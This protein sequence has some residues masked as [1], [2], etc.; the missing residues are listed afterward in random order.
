[1]E[2]ETQ[3][4]TFVVR[5]RAAFVRVALYIRHHSLF[6]SPQLPV[7]VSAYQLLQFLSLLL[8][9]AYP[10]GQGLASALSLVLHT[11][12]QP[13]VSAVTYGLPTFT[14]LFL[15]VF[16]VIGLVL[17]TCYL[18]VRFYSLHEYE[19]Q[20]VLKLQTHLPLVGP[21]SKLL[22][23]VLLLS[24]LLFLP[25]IDYFNHEIS[26][27]VY[28]YP[29]QVLFLLQICLLRLFFT[30]TK[31]QNRSFSSISHPIFSLYQAATYFLLPFSLYIFPYPERCLLHI[32][33]YLFLGG[34]WSYQL[35]FFLPYQRNLLNNLEL[36]KGIMIFWTGVMIVIGKINGLEGEMFLTMHIITNIGVFAVVLLAEQTYKERILKKRSISYKFELELR[37]RWHLQG[38]FGS[39]NTGKGKI[40]K[41][42]RRKLD[43][44]EINSLC[45]DAYS[46]FP[47][48]PYI[49]MRLLEYF[50]LLKE[51]VFAKTLLARLQHADHSFLTRL[52]LKCSEFHAI[53]VLTK[54]KTDSD[55]G[56]FMQ[57]A[58][59]LQ[60]TKHTDEEMTVLAL[61]LGEMFQSPALDVAETSKIL[62]NTIKIVLKTKKTYEILYRILGENEEFVKQ[63]LSFMRFLRDTEK[64]SSLEGRM[65]QLNQNKKTKLHFK[66]ES[67]FFQDE[68]SCVLLV[69]LEKG[70]AGRILA[71][72]ST[73]VLGFMESE[74]QDSN[75]TGLIPA[76]FVGSH[77]ANF[78]NIHK[79]RHSSKIYA[80]PQLVYIVS[81]DGF[82]RKAVW[83]LRLVNYE[84]GKLGALIALKL[85]PDGLEI[86]TIAENCISQTT[87]SFYQ[88][89][90]VSHSQPILEAK[91]RELTDW[92]TEVSLLQCK[93]AFGYVDFK[94]CSRTFV[95]STKYRVVVMDKK[96]F[97]PLQSIPTSS[98]SVFFDFSEQA[99]NG[100]NETKIPVSTSN[101]SISSD[102]S[103][104]FHYISYQNRLLKVYFGLSFLCLLLS[105]ICQIGI[106]FVINAQKADLSVDLDYMGSLGELRTE[107]ILSAVD[108]SELNTLGEVNR[109]RNKE[110]LKTD[111]VIK[112]N[113]MENLAEKLLILAS[114]DSPE[115]TEKRIVWWEIIGKTAVFS[116][117]NSIE[118]ASISALRLRK[119]ADSGV[120]D[121]ASVLLF[122]RNA[123]FETKLCLSRLINERLDFHE[124]YN[125]SDRLKLVTPLL[126]VFCGVMVA[127]ALGLIWIAG[128]VSYRRK[129]LWKEANKLDHETVHAYGM[130]VRQRLEE[131][132]NMEAMQ[133]RWKG[134]R[135]LRYKVHWKIWGL[136]VNLGAVLALGVGLFMLN[137]Q[138]AF[139]S[140]QESQ[141]H[142]PY[143]IHATGLQQTLLAEVIFWL[144]ELTL[145]PA[146]QLTSLYPANTQ[147]PS[148][149]IAL[150]DAFQELTDTQMKLR[151]DYSSDLQ[152]TQEHFQFLYGAETQTTAELS[153][154]YTPA[155]NYI[156]NLVS[157]C[158]SA[159]PVS[160]KYWETCGSTDALTYS[161]LNSTRT[162]QGY[163]LNMG[164]S[165]VTESVSIVAELIGV[166][167]VI[168][169]VYSLAALVPVCALV[170]KLGR[171]EVELVPLLLK[172]AGKEQFIRTNSTRRP[173]IV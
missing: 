47:T 133:N 75:C 19:F 119:C 126:G 152:I 77:T 112:A 82:L 105:I 31:L 125:A 129:T 40:T 59:N 85:V 83:K 106:I 159:E 97:V 22:S 2:S 55:A 70:S 16:L 66:D 52:D 29:L 94:A 168:V 151:F 150:F 123:A 155:M 57:I 71:C 89:L 21:V 50:L 48:E 110:D 153:R 17:P 128:Q 158:L 23:W 149:E 6:H 160:K 99:S 115:L 137:Y 69:T 107:L 18:F 156:K 4:H 102:K 116:M 44:G 14:S 32:S 39:V 101:T 171:T 103:A 170:D 80:R 26:F 54:S 164:D 3:D 68:Q 113:F 130:K 38:F 86:A 49:L 37:L 51:I 5:C 138:V 173:S 169:L 74:L 163:Y 114:E 144:R 132:H 28:F 1:M 172:I 146:L 36:L 109:G 15:L 53:S 100:A 84:P 42:M 63:Y 62:T 7:L 88:V 127:S 45:E 35:F 96:S 166:S 61:R 34:F 93:G 131:V 122:L 73:H 58:S 46:R 124:K 120:A 147:P 30:P 65:K 91:I 76:V 64:I 143:A 141:Y 11:L 25:I 13:L 60:S 111:L 108:I 20:R 165:V 161:L 56:Q 157:A 87:E 78:R 121:P 142:Q 98:K 79:F 43:T 81:K 104:N 10:S 24:E 154:G 134:S 12:G 118:I 9:P 162:N 67:L 92:D 90:K 145:P 136:W 140:M 41:E 135:R 27:Q 139:I 72:K 95:S 33:M 148:A 8:N 167:A 117:K